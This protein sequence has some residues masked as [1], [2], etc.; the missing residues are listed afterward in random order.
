VPL[1]MR[2][3]MLSSGLAACNSAQAVG[4]NA[5][6]QRPSIASRKSLEPGK[7]IGQIYSW[8]TE[9]YVS[10]DSFSFWTFQTFSLVELVFQGVPMVLLVFQRHTGTSQGL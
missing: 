8:C 9:R 2:P 7:P 4:L 10:A 6:I 3:E 1:V 5:R